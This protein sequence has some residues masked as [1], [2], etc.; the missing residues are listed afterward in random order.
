MNEYRLARPVPDP[1]ERPGSQQI[2]F[3]HRPDCRKGNL[4]AATLPSLVAA[5]FLLLLPAIFLVMAMPAAAGMDVM[6]NQQLSEAQAGTMAELGIYEDFYRK[7]FDYD[8]TEPHDPDFTADDSWTPENVTVVR[9]SSDIYIEN[10]G[11]LGALKMGDYDRTVE[12]LGEL[13]SMDSNYTM[14]YGPNRRSN[15]GV[16]AD[17]HGREMREEFTSGDTVDNPYRETTANR[18]D[19]IFDRYGAG[20]TGDTITLGQTAYRRSDTRPPDKVG[21][22]LWDAHPETPSDINW[23]AKQDGAS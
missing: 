4:P 13:A 5:F 17:G 11:E 9:L 8:A 6:T 18:E 3:A 14:V 22:E 20:T 12:E 1:P 19:I 23:E 2:I 16:S 15:P 10:Y 7:N 21:S